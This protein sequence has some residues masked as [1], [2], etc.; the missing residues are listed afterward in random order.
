MSERQV[1]KEQILQ[2]SLNFTSVELYRQRAALDSG[3]EKASSQEKTRHKGNY[4]LAELS[5]N[6]PCPFK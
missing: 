1:F 4:K 6:R 3:E 2:I 5:R